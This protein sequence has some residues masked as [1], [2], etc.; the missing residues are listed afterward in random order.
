MLGPRW[1]KAVSSYFVVRLLSCVR[2]PVTPWT[3]AGQ[4]ALSSAISRS[5]C[6]FTFIESLMPFN[7]LILSPPSPPAFSLSQHQGLFQWVSSSH[8]MAKVLEIQLQHQPLQWIFRVDFF[9]D[10]LVWSPC[11]PMDSQESSPKPQFRSINFWY[12]DFFMVQCSHVYLTTGKKHSFDYS[13]ICRQINVY[14]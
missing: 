10:W 2:L 1:P 11:C 9:Q 13:D 3:A 7:H 8:Q 12:S 4:A 5:L 14:F 6:K